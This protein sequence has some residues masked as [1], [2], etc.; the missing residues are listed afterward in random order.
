MPK[1]GRVLPLIDTSPIAAQIVPR[2]RRHIGSAPS[3]G[4]PY[5]KMRSLSPHGIDPSP[6]LRRTPYRVIQ[7]I[8]AI[9]DFWEGRQ[10]GSVIKERDIK[11]FNG[12]PG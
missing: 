9:G 5:Q 6:S 2:R 7:Q 3:N 1:E 10:R 11:A 12:G 4:L 8:G